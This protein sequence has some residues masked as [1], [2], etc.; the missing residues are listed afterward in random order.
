MP[1]VWGV[2]MIIL[3]FFITWMTIITAGHIEK[4][5]DIVLF[6]V[7]IAF[8]MP[9]FFCLAS[10]ISR[11]IIRDYNFLKHARKSIATVIRVE[12]VS[13]HESDKIDKILNH[14]YKARWRLTYSFNPPDDLS[15]DNL[16]HT[17]ETYVKPDV[18]EGDLLP[19]LYL[20]QNKKN[21]EKVYSSPYPLPGD[22]E[23]RVFPSLSTWLP[24]LISPLSKTGSL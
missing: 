1:V 24:W 20:I 17:V 3:F 2:V 4:I 18:K 5:G 7:L 13:Q 10:S 6:V 23:I 22:D 8:I 9:M 16:I 11:G 15:P 12:Y 14:S 21:I 19:I